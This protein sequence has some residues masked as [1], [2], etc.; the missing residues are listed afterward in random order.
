MSAATRSPESSDWRTFAG[1]GE[2]LVSTN[3]LGAQRE[4][5]INMTR[6]L[7]A[8]KV[9]VWLH[10]SLFRLPDRD[11]EYLFPPEP[12]LDEMLEAF[13]SGKPVIHSSPSEDSSNGI[14]A[15]FPLEERGFILRV[16]R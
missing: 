9:D 16:L 11:D 10:E 15:A 6:R 13:H 5:I 12:E 4:R 14:C 1:L 7:V 2:Q 3:S 8:G